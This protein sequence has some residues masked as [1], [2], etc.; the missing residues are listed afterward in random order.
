MQSC[1]GARP[2]GLVAV[3][4][5]EWLRCA[6]LPRIRA[7]AR[8]NFSEHGHP[9]WF[10][11][12]AYQR[13][14]AAF[15]LPPSGMEPRFLLALDADARHSMRHMWPQIDRPRAPP[16][17]PQDRRLIPAGQAGHIPL[18]P[19]YNYV[20]SAPRVPDAIQFPIE[21]VFSGVKV[22]FRRILR[23]LPNARARDMVAAMTEAFERSATPDSIRHRFEH[24]ERNMRVFCGEDGSVVVIDGV[25]YHCPYGGW[26]PA[27]LRA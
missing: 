13:L 2:G 3:E 1:T 24:G 11:W 21:S 20:P 10:S 22:Q 14:C 15:D 4:F 17:P 8:A 19:V 5:Q 9:A 12:A 16:A 23:S 6:A 7:F 26:L 18:H 25:S 27:V